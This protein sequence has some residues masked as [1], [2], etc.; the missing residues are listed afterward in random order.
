MSIPVSGSEVLRPDGFSAFFGCKC[1]NECEYVAGVRIFDIIHSSRIRHDR[2]HFFLE[3]FW[4]VEEP[5]KVPVGLAHLAPVDPRQDR[6]VFFNVLSGES[7]Y[8]LFVGFIERFRDVAGHL[9]MLLLI[10]SDGDDIRVVADYVRSHE[11]RIVEDSHIE[12]RSLC[13]GVLEAMCSE[14]ERIG[15]DIV[16]D[17][18]EA[19]DEDDIGLTEDRD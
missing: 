5:D 7:E 3:G 1:F 13:L 11:Y 2:H 17:P 4:V 18:V 19:G 9:Q 10:L 16:E 8:L 14:H 6:H 15:G 12:I